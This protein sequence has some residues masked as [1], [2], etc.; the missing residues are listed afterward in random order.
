MKNFSINAE[1]KGIRNSE[2]IA[3]EKRH[4]YFCEPRMKT[5]F[6]RLSDAIKKVDFIKANGRESLFVIVLQNNEYRIA[7]KTDNKN[8]VVWTE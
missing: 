4:I 5:F 3:D 7:F 2:K 6:K 8:N 1:T